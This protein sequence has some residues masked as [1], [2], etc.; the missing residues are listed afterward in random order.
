MA[1]HAQPRKV[2]ELKGSV[3]KNPQRYAA[4]EEQPVN[5][6]GIGEP[7]AYMSADAKKCWYEILDNCLPGVMTGAERFVV[8]IAATLLSQFRKKPDKFPSAKYT[9]MVGV[10]ARLGM[11]PAD[12]QKIQLPRNPKDEDPFEK[13]MAKTTPK[14]KA[15][16]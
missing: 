5:T 14:R 7:P 8:E 2:A 15:D 9:Q 16:A 3:K 6:H 11:S 12:R 4:A 10:F 1:R 13:F